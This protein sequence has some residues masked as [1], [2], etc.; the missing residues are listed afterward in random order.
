MSDGVEHSV[1]VSTEQAMARLRPWLQDRTAG[2]SDLRIGQVIEPSQGLS[3][4]T[5]LF[6]ASWVTDA[7]THS[8]GLVARIGRQTACPLLGDIFHQY[9]VMAAI[10]AA[11]AAPVPTLV[12]AE[13]DAAVL[14]APFFLM[15]QVKGRVPGDFPSYHQQGWFA[16]ALSPAQRELAWWNGVKAMAQVHRAGWQPFGFLAPHGAAA[17][18]EPPTAGDYLEHF[19]AA[20]FTWAAEGQSYPLLEAAIRHLSETQPA[21]EDQQAGLVWNDARMGNTMF[22]PDLQ[23]A[24]LF[25]FEVASLGPPEIDL[26]WWLYAEDIFSLQF[27]HPRLA[28]IP[29][30]AEAIR[31]FEQLYGRAMPHFE[32]FEAI[33]ALKHAVISIRDYRNSKKIKKPDALPNFATG[34]LAAYLQ[35]QGV[36]P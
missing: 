24:A 32:Y 31:G 10:R 15:D 26:A 9:R 7:Q 12:L 5:I 29:S 20:W 35:A 33:A 19:I 21:S 25:D 27:G 34:R 17:L 4:K 23:V 13:S 18:T 2:A 1:E 30:R 6:E 14:G 16:E 28:G 8:R 3:S 22:G 11:S 36:W